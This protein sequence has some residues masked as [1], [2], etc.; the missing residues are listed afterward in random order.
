MQSVF[1]GKNPT[2]DNPPTPSFC[3]A[4]TLKENTTTRRYMANLNPKRTKR[5]NQSSLVRTLKGMTPRHRSS[6]YAAFGEISKR[7]TPQ[8]SPSRYAAF[9]KISKRTTPDTVLQ[10]MRPSAGYFNGRPL[11]TGLKSM[12]PTRTQVHTHMHAKLNA[13]PPLA[14]G[15]EGYRESSTR[16]QKS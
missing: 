7:T 6:R 11:D 1:L 15:C 4:K 9:G 3:Q 5:C 16:G 10:S 2:R 13:R 8:H 12:R 14:C